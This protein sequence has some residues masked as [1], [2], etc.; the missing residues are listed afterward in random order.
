VT[1][2]GDY[3]Q[4]QKIAHEIFTDP[5]LKQEKA[6]ITVLNGSTKAGIGSQVADEL[7]VYNYTI[8]KLAKS[9]QPAAKTIIYDQT[10]GS[11]KVT[12]E[13]LK[14][15][16]NAPVVTTVP[17]LVLTDAGQADIIVLLGDDYRASQKAQ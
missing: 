12:L 17:P 14:K 15:R 6:N 16:L 7:K 4:L 13:L 11:K 1:K 2:T 9:S 3:S 8:S 5:Y 10:Q